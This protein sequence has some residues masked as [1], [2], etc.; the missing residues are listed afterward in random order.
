MLIIFSI[1]KK[2]PT[3]NPIRIEIKADEMIISCKSNIL[4]TIIE[5]ITMVL[6]SK[7]PGSLDN[8]FFIKMWFNLTFIKYI[9]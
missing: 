7:I 5:I 3:N 1:L 8:I 9:N 4:L 2:F 6:I